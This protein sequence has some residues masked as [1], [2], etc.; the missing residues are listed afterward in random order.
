LDIPDAM[1]QDQDMGPEGVLTL[2]WLIRLR[3]AALAI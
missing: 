1:L 3:W 2:S